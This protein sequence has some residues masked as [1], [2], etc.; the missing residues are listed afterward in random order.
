MDKIIKQLL[1]N[2]AGFEWDENNKYKNSVKHQVHY[3]EC[4]EAFFNE[5]L[6]VY[7]DKKHSEKETRFYLLGHTNM[8]RSLFIVFTVRNNKIRVISAR[9]MNKKEKEIYKN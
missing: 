5:P 2:C 3:I 8:S 6:I 4:E 7:F 9:D 1:F